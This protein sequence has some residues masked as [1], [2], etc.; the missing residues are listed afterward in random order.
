MKAA[1]DHLGPGS[2]TVVVTSDNELFA[3]TVQAALTIAGRNEFAAPHA[4]I[5]RRNRFY[6][7]HESRRAELALHLGKL[8]RAPS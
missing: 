3:L 6:P 8:Q 4:H 2:E 1:T 5:S 7:L